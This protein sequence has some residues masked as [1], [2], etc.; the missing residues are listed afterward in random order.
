M[1]VARGEPS[2]RW[3]WRVRAEGR[4]EGPEMV[5]EEGMGGS[6]VES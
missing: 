2:G 4:V 6:E 1:R 3:V 5:G